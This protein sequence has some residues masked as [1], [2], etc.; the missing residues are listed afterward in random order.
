MI[1]HKTLAAGKWFELS[2]VEQMANIGVDFERAVRWRKKGDEELSKK[3]FERVLEL[4]DLTKS[5]PKLRGRGALREVCRVK[6]TLIDFF[7]YD[8]QYDATQEQWSKYFY[9]FNYAA[10]MQRGR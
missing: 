5:D 9:Q 2:L 6:E 7:M 10:A 8:N 3:A 1:I 4:L